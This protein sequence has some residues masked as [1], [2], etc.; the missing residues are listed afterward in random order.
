MP[1]S[2]L[3]YILLGIFL[4]SFGVHN[5]YAGFTNKA[6]VQLLISVVSCGILSWISFI[7]AVVDIITTTHDAN[8]IRML[9]S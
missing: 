5:F 9:E 2:R 4:G 6:I 7:W 3:A 1:K 8:G